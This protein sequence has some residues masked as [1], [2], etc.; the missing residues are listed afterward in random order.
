MISSEDAL[1]FSAWP[2]TMDDLQTAKHINE[3]PER[4]LITVNIDHL[5][6]GVGGDDS[7]SHKAQ[8]HPEFRIPAQNY[9]YS[10]RIGPAGS[11]RGSYRLPKF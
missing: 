2:Y 11:P 4:N 1:N 3:L 9:R 10:F 5:Q 7:W 6:M 8:P